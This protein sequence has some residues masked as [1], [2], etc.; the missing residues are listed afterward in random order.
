MAH[1]RIATLLFIAIW[2]SVAVA[3]VPAPWFTAE[4]STNGG[5]NFVPVSPAPWATEVGAGAFQITP[6]I[7]SYPFNG[8][9]TRWVLQEVGSRAELR[10]HVADFPRHFLEGAPVLG[11]FVNGFRFATI[12]ISKD[13]PGETVEASVGTMQVSRASVRWLGVALDWP[14]VAVL[15]SADGQQWAPIAEANLTVVG[16]YHVAFG[17]SDCA[18]GVSP[19]VPVNYDNVSLGFDPVAV[20]GATWGRVKSLFR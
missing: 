13:G 17:I 18:G 19:V 6:D 20:E 2:C 15:T 14:W 4:G 7:F 5:L 11:L 8:A 1:T 10:A 3:D 9:G 16:S 12:A